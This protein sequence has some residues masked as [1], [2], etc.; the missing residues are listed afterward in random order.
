MV[1]I[2]EPLSKTAL[3]L[4]VLFDSFVYDDPP[5]SYSVSASISPDS[6]LSFLHEILCGAMADL[7]ETRS[8]CM[9]ALGL[10]AFSTKY[11][12]KL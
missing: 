11:Q 12:I 3:T 8:K 9:R 6:V 5:Y 4:L 1:L 2:L 7:A 10:L